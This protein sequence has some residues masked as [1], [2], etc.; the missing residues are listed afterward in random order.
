M[1]QK[2]LWEKYMGDNIYCDAELFCTEYGALR[3]NIVACVWRSFL[4]VRNKESNIGGDKYVMTSNVAMSLYNQPC[5]MQRKPDYCVQAEYCRLLGI[6]VPSASLEKWQ[7]ANKLRESQSKKNQTEAE[8]IKR[9][10]WKK[11][12][13]ERQE[14]ERFE[15]GE[16]EQ[17]QL[18][19]RRA[20]RGFYS[21]RGT[22][23]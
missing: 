10:V 6:P 21:R 2:K 3:T 18:Q 1:A 20:F 8:K 7:K 19:Q 12:K 23:Q 22:D 15:A 5:I 11:T 9:A 14:E 17:R 4:K 16:E 13:R